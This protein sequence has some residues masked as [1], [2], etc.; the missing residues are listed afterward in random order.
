MGKMYGCMMQIQSY[1]KKD[2]CGSKPQRYLFFRAV[3][4][5]AH[6]ISNVYRVVY[7]GSPLFLTIYVYLF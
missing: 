6:W 1:I 3:V 4:L 5:V 2:T 7:F